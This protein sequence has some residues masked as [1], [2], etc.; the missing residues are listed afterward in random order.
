MKH[1]LLLL[2]VV[3]FPVLLVAQ[4]SQFSQKEQD[5]ILK[6]F[7]KTFKNKEADLDEIEKQAN[8]FIEKIGKMVAYDVIAHP[9]IDSIRIDS[10]KIDDTISVVLTY[11]SDNQLYTINPNDEY[12]KDG[13]IPLMHFFNTM[14]YGDGIESVVMSTLFTFSFTN[15]NIVYKIEYELV[16]HNDSTTIKNRKIQ[17]ITPT[18]RLNEN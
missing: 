12:E 7:T 10:S 18:E 11:S 8:N 3:F 5:K 14:Y 16:N 9:V 1:Y 15:K 6:Q 13:S 17:E 2:W 4:T